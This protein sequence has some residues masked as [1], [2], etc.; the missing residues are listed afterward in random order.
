MGACC[1]GQDLDAGEDWALR[2]EAERIFALADKDSDGKLDMNELAN[3]RN[4]RQ[5]AEA[6]MG[7]VDK[8]MNGSISVEEWSS[9]VKGIFDK[10]E[11]A[12]ANVL[13]LY[14]KQI[15]ENKD[16]RLKAAA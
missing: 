7:A 2:S 5:F 12:A 15:G 4:S 8:D 16:I 11:K 14:E 10:N 6:M 13:K 3:L 9:Y 1:A